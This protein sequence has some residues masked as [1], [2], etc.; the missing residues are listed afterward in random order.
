[1][2]HLL[3]LL[4]IDM[5]SKALESQALI[6]KLGYDYEVRSSSCLFREEREL[7]GKVKVLRGSCFCWE[8]SLFLRL[9][10]SCYYRYIHTNHDVQVVGVGWASVVPKRR[11]ILHI[12][13]KS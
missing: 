11:V 5:C 4:K 8:G 10:S 9:H 7:K 3:F 2:Y 12:D 6:G 1:M 13:L